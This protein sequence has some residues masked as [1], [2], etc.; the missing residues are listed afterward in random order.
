MKWWYWLILETLIIFGVM[1]WIFFS[2]GEPEQD[3]GK[4]L[5]GYVFIY[6]IEKYREIKRG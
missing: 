5:I 6:V 1:T 2:P 4:A 3:I